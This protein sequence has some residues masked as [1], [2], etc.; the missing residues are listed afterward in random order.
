LA[1]FPWFD[2]T[3][4]C[5]DSRTPLPARFVSFAR[6][7]LPLASVFVTPA[8]PDADLGP[9][10]F[11]SGN[12]LQPAVSGV[13]TPGRPKFLE[14]PSVP[15]PCSRTPAGPT[16][17]AKTL[18]QHGPRTFNNEGSQ[19]QVISGLNRTAS[20]LT[21]YASPGPL[22]DRTQDSFLVAGQALPGGI[23]TRRVPTK[24]FYDVATSLPPFPSF[25][26]Q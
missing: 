26:A 2:G 5:S 15:T 22:L 19:R 9:G 1:P 14:N 13:E 16:Q 8:K 11:G 12:P 23:H 7:L 17:L 24:G 21:V 18:R 3:M 6:R 10:V 20:A 25:L 4:E